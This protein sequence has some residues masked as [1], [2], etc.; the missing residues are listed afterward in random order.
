MS[1]MS[2]GGGSGGLF[3]DPLELALIAGT[4]I[5]APY[6]AP[7]LFEG[8]ALAGST[9]LG[10]GVAGAG[11]GGLANAAMGRNAVQGMEMGALGGAG[12][13]ALGVNSAATLGAGTVAPAASLGAGE[14]IVGGVG[15]TGTGLGLT[16]TQAAMGLGGIGLAGAMTADKAKYGVPANSA[17]NWNG[18]SLSNFRYDPR[19][20][21]PDTVT[22]PNPA[23]QAQYKQRQQQQDQAQTTPYQPV[24][25]AGGGLMQDQTNFA[26]GGMYPMSQQDHTQF[27]TSPQ[28]PASMQATMASYDPE[29]NPL[30]GEPTA[31]MASGGDVGKFN[32][33]LADP[34]G[35]KLQP[36][37]MY[38]QVSQ[39]PNSLLPQDILN[40][41]QANGFAGGNGGFDFPHFGGPTS[42]SAQG[43]A[44]GGMMNGGIADLGSYS[45]GGQ[46]LKGPG[47]G[48]SD[49]IPARIGRKQPARLADSE[50]VVPADVVSHLGNGSSDAGAKKLYAMMNNVRKARTGKNKQAPKINADKYLPR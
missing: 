46:L 47:D 48:M 6:A 39:D 19:S 44:A 26:N 9:M 37:M 8:G 24:Y 50:F 35:Y 21:N 4:A 40:I 31:H 7:L 5:A 45:D 20:Y 28:M 1:G 34:T 43:H 22:P 13:S 27:A 42:S 38:T 3:S 23:Y 41:M 36:S 15:A 16:G 49:S 12:G 17:V 29:T 30:T 32:T 25:A 14:S 11:I 18:G 33:P 10:A 2:G